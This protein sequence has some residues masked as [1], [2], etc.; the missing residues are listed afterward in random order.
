MVDSSALTKSDFEAA[1]DGVRVT[2]ITNQGGNRITYLVNLASG[3]AYINDS[4]KTQFRLYFSL[5][6]NS[7]R[8]NDYTVFYPSSNNNESRRPR[9]VVQYEQ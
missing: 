6:D 4:G 1:A 5:D 2:Q 9:L 7:D 8:S 3:L